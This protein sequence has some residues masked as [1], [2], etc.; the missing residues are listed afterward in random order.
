[1]VTSKRAWPA[2]NVL[3]GVNILLHD[4]YDNKAFN[5][6]KTVLLYLSFCLFP[7]GLP[8]N[9]FIVSECTQVKLIFLSVLAMA[10]EISL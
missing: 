1:M 5:H 7:Y 6:D 3:F 9:W 8:L 10:I 4:R 2:F